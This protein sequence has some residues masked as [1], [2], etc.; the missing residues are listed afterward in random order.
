MTYA[1]ILM[2]KLCT[3]NQWYFDD[4]EKYEVV[5][6]GK[7]TV[8][9]IWKDM[10]IEFDD[11]LNEIAL[12]DFYYSLLDEGLSEDDLTSEELEDKFWMLIESDETIWSYL[13]IEYRWLK[14][15]GC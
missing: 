10:A 6:D 8:Y 5:D 4:N 13:D 9:I 12:K 14:E 1:Q 15:N 3:S 2:D 7:G 11:L